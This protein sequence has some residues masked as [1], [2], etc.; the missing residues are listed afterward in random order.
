MN[1]SLYSALLYLLSPLLILYLA[2]RALKSPDYRGRWGE[3]F[4]L[5]KLSRADLLI[6]SVSMGETLAA[7]PLIKQIQAAY[8]ELS[9]TITTTSP[10]GSAEVVKAFGESV[11]HC[12]LPFDLPLCVAR[13]LS[14]LQPKEII[15]METELWPNLIHQAKRRGIKLML[16]NARLSERSANQYRGRPKLSLPMLR[17]LDTIAAQSPQAAQRFIDLG[18]EAER[19][20][21][22]GSLKFDL[23]IAP[24]LLEQAKG[25]RQTWQRMETPV[26]VAGSVHPG[27]FD[28]MLAAHKS[29]LMRFPHAL[30]VLVP[31]HPE[32]FDAAASRVKAAGLKLARRSKQERVDDQTQVLLGDTMGEL[33]SFY[34]AAD[35]AF[36]GGTLIENG[37]HNPL[38]PAAIGL[39]VYVGPHHWDFAEITGLLNESGSLALVQDADELAE[40]LVYKFDDKAAYLAA[41]KAGLEVVEANKGALAAQF[42]LASELIKA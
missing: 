23:S 38:E 40:Q 24:E 39:P 1:R 30:L 27:E 42:A 32:Q 34:G 7:I 5:S 6:H 17:S 12:Y 21:V 16:A 36:V 14:Q 8:P 22:T 33:L 2:I 11:Q 19:V 10:T 3:R 9:I 4:G 31:R 37:G 29:L 15:I 35:Q 13:F 25:L 18:V 20:K 28:I 41:R 26:W